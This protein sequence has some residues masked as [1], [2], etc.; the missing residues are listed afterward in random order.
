MSYDFIFFLIYIIFLWDKDSA[1]HISICSST[2]LNFPSSQVGVMLTRLSL[3]AKAVKSLCASF[4]SLFP[5]E[6][7]V[8]AMGTISA[9]TTKE[10]CLVSMG[11]R[12]E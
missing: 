3:W 2:F 7:S 6:E 4:I 12:R 8:Q 11:M 1:H 10:D 5:S 9:N